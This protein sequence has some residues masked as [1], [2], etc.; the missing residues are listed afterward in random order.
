MKILTITLGDGTEIQIPITTSII[1]PTR[2]FYVFE[3]VDDTGSVIKVRVES[4]EN[5]NDRTDRGC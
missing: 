1:E 3:G 4:Q 2:G 5:L